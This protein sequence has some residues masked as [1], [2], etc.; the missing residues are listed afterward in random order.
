VWRSGGDYDANVTAALF[1]INDKKN[2]W[3]V[4]GKFANSRLIGFNPDGST[5]SGYSHSIGM[6]KTSGRFNFNVGQDLTDD[7][8]NSRDMGYFNFGNTLDHYAWVGYRWIKPK[9]WYNN[10]YLNFNAFYSR[11]L[12]PSIYRS[13][14]FN[15]NVNGQ[16][17]NLWYAG[18]L[19]GYEPKYNDF[20]ESRKEGLI[21]PAWS[22]Y[23]VNGWFETNTAKKYSF[24]AELMY[25]KRSLFGSE[26]YSF[27][28]QNRYRFSDKIT[29]SYN[30]NMAPQNDN[31]G[32]AGFEGSDV[33]MGR[34]DIKQ[35]ENVMNFKYS[36]NA[37]M[38]I[39][40]RVRHYW[41]KV[42]YNEFFT[43]EENG[44]LTPNSTFIVNPNN[45]PD[46]NYNVFNVD[47]VY[48]WQFAPGSFINLVWKNWADDFH[49]V[50]GDSYFKNFRSTMRD[51]HVN[52]IS[53]KVIYFLDYLQLKKMKKKA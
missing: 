15:A 42:I 49:R 38:N 22:D 30:L 29:V 18:A 32:F 53:F 6:G 3:N 20:F 50:T 39:N 40:V 44:N 26:R 23:Y 1:S 27:S 8:F 17:K 31:T 12:K 7:K 11:Q 24:Y 16:L 9:K 37:K 13:A 46:Q 47:A 48:T 35:V 21:F 33:V 34:R 51:N 14:N 5:K 4:N 43:L 28:S 45:N 2:M 41:T 10:I 19:I 52:D 25:V 36:F